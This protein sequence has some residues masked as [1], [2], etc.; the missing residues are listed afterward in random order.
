MASLGMILLII[1]RSR[2]QSWTMGSVSSP[3]KWH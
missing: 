1:S 2:L 3:A